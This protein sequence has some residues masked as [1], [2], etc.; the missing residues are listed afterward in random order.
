MRS[1]IRCKELPTWTGKAIVWGVHKS[2]ADKR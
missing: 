2:S 1:V